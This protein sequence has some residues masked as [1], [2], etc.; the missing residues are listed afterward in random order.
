MVSIQT[1]GVTGYLNS[2]ETDHKCGVHTD[3][4]ELGL[5]EVTRHFA[6]SEG[7]IAARDNYDH[8]VYRRNQEAE[9]KPAVDF[10]MLYS[11]AWK[12][13]FRF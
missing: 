12:Q 5:I 7:K 4:D 13:K 2:S 9:T 10:E 1:L 6:G 8:V 3:G 11:L